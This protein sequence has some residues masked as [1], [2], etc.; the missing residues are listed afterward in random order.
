MFPSHD[1]VVTAVPECGRY[2][3]LD[4]LET[5]TDAFAAAHPG[6]EVW[7]AGA[8]RAFSL[9]DDYDYYEKYGADPAILLT[10]GT[11]SDAYAEAAWGCFTLVAEVPYFTSAKIADKRR[12]A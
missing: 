10:S 1:A 3:L 8:S 9:A 7:P 12:P 11:S 4:E 5:S 2:P 6:V